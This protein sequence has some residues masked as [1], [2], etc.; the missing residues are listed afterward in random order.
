MTRSNDDEGAHVTENL[1][2]QP[3]AK[4]SHT[5]TILEIVGGVVAVGLILFSGVFGFVVGHVTAKHDGHRD[6]RYVE[7]QFE[8]RNGP[9]FQGGPGLQLPTPSMPQG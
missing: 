1:P 6:G 9:G 2:E 5:R 3:V 7:R 4:Q 8:M